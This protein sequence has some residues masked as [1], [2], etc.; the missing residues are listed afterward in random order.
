MATPQ[1]VLGLLFG[2]I[3][4]AYFRYGKKRSNMVIRYSGVGMMVYPY[5]ISNTF[6]AIAVGLLLM[7]LPKLYSRF[8]E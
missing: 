1:I 5:F 6:L 8:F 2:A 4:F 7:A 3:G